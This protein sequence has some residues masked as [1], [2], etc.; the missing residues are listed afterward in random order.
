MAK[1]ISKNVRSNI[2]VIDVDYWADYGINGLETVIGQ[3]EEALS[4]VEEKEDKFWGIMNSEETT[5][6]LTNGQVIKGFQ[7]KKFGG[8]KLLR[9]KFDE[10]GYKAFDELVFVE[11][12]EGY[13]VKTKRTVFEAV[14]KILEHYGLEKP[15][16][17]EAVRV[18]RD[19]FWVTRRSFKKVEFDVKELED[20]KYLKDIKEEEDNSFDPTKI[21]DFFLEDSEEEF[22]MFSLE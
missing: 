10:K 21:D 2:Q 6:R 16:A 12:D 11:E 8:Y 5:I 20:L 22:D 18:Y 1:N 3:K 14:D 7:L 15:K 19:I 17:K 13:G 9:A 4:L